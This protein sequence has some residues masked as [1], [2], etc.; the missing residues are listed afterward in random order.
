MTQA[1][2]SA[3]ING[4]LYQ[5]LHHIDL[6]AMVHWTEYQSGKWLVILEPKNGGD[7][8]TETHSFRCVEQYKTKTRGTWSVGE[9][10]NVLKDLRRAVQ[11]PHG[12]NA[13]YRFVTSGRRGKLDPFDEFLRRVRSTRT[14]DELDDTIERKFSNKLAMSDRKFFD[15]I[16]LN[17]RSG[18]TPPMPEQLADLIHLLSHFDMEFD[19]TAE[20]VARRIDKELRRYVPHLGSESSIRNQLVGALMERLGSGEATLDIEEIKT[21]FKDVGLVPDRMHKLARLRR[22]MNSI[23]AERLNRVNYDPLLDVRPKPEWHSDKHVLLISGKSG[24]G[25]SWQLGSLM[26]SLHQQEKLTT[27]VNVIE[28]TGESLLDKAARDIWQRGL[29]ETTDHTLIAVSNHLKDLRYSDRELALAFDDV[30]DPTVARRLI[31]EDWSTLGMRLVLT[32]PEVVAQSL[33]NELDV[34]RLPVTDF[35]IHE[36]QDAF[37]RAS[38]N[39]EELPNDLQKIL[40]KPILAGIFFRLEHL[41]FRESP[42]SEYEIFEQFWLRIAD[43]G[44]PHDT[45]IIMELAKHVINSKSYPVPRNQW[46]DL[47]LDS[48]ALERLQTA[49]WLQ[50]DDGDVGFAHD[51]LLN[52]AVAK[53]LAHSHALGRLSISELTESLTK[54]V[55]GS[56]VSE[57]TRLGYV[58]M[59][60]I[61]LLSRND[62]KDSDLAELVEH[63]DES[64]EFGSY[65]ETL[66]AQL[67]PT[68]GLH[69]VP[70]L[71]RRLQNITSEN[72][73]DYRV[74]LIGLGFSALA[75]Q[76]EVPIENVIDSLLK[77]DSTGCQNAALTV[78]EKM[79]IRASLDRIWELLQHRRALL[80]TQKGSISNDD[81]SVAFDALRNEIRQ[82]P[83]WLRHRL[84]NWTGSDDSLP[85][86]AHQL[87]ALD[88]PDAADIWNESKTMLMEQM[89]RNKLRGLLMCIARFKDAEYLD[90]VQ[91]CLTEREDSADSAAFYTLTVI[92]PV[93]AVER[94]A[95]VRAVGRFFYRN[96]W[97][98][99]LLHAQANMTRQRVLEFAEADKLSF[100]DIYDVFGVR[101]NQIDKP[102]LQFLLR[103]L[104]R[105]L[106]DSPESALAESPN[107]LHLRLEF[108]NRITRPDLLSVIDTEKDGD[109]ELMITQVACSQLGGGSR[110]SRDP[111]FRSARRFLLTIGGRGFETVLQQ[112]IASNNQYERIEALS[113]VVVCPENDD[114][115]SAVTA[116][117]R[118]ISVRDGG[119]IDSLDRI[120]FSLVTEALAHCGEDKALVEVIE[121]NGYIDV[122][123]DIAHYRT[124][125]GQMSNQLTA[126]ARNVLTA[127]DA[128]EDQILFALTVAGVSGDPSMLD[129]IHA[130][131][132]VSTP[133]DVV[134]TRACFALQSLGDTSEAFVECASSLLNRE[135][136]EQFALE[137][138]AS[139]GEVGC[140]RIAAWLDSRVPERFGPLETDVIRLL[141]QNPSTRMAAVDAAVAACRH[142]EG[143][144]DP[145]YEI[146][147]ESEDTNLRERI[148]EVAFDSDPLISDHGVRAIE[149]LAKFDIASAVLA[150]YQAI[151]RSPL[152]KRVFSILSSIAPKTAIRSL[153]DTAVTTKRTVLRE[154]IGRTLRRLEVSEVYDRV[155]EYLHDGTSEQRRAAAQ[156][157]RWPTDSRFVETLKITADSDSNI[158]VRLAAMAA[159]DARNEE[160]IIRDLL[161]DFRTASP[162]RK[163]SFLNSILETGDPYLLSDP[164]DELGLGSVLSEL[165][166]TFTL[167]AN[168]VLSN[169]QLEEDQ[170]YTKQDFQE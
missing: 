75:R 166:Q 7:A 11:C 139:T 55:A 50:H 37:A 12:K 98:S 32:V 109:L 135:G 126:S 158:D 29:G 13:Q 167:H 121:R 112:Q 19:V 116:A 5:M 147:A 160:L 69:A 49:G 155:V 33:H 138:L 10:T 89:P 91:E 79:P 53:S 142:G 8:L 2:G 42:H 95:D 157:A 68:L 72:E 124:H 146:A 70:M 62:T 163:W 148:F 143:M 149:G 26:H 51:R 119:A 110:L 20:R 127:S 128:T 71:V 63:L 141:H 87:N 104:E 47:G 23:T 169:K 108:L 100:V 106:R 34:Q 88:H 4:F 168:D 21:L 114:I 145:P 99:M 39:W 154:W 9:L 152:N 151:N 27:L 137:A 64:K 129:R 58:P 150:A 134:V 156:L 16:E 38:Y 132:Q 170:K 111:V 3:A 102:I 83:D 59:D 161:A 140:S 97:S 15:H 144:L 66:Y 43:K 84:T 1:G 30:R 153:V 115:R 107:W 103:T 125:F 74:K 25:K 82:N 41:S 96:R 46:S 56:V 45:G 35:S 54:T 6:T 65:G 76:G 24:S 36:L 93:K 31:S 90:F 48:K 122:P 61:W 165:P 77:S 105:E 162:R 18:H 159:I 94:L 67:L 44:H 120:E 28:G 85:T 86:L 164:V 136:C 123:S 78:L 80:D 113:W 17:T 101:P 92:D 131:L 117:S 60:A 22:T 81:Y 57:P 52:W 40:R 14:A 118:A 73:R 130:F 133:S